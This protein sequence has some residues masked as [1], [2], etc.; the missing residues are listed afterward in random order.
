MNCQICDGKLMKRN[1]LYRVYDTKLGTFPADVCERCGEQWFDEKTAKKIEAIEKKKGL[2]G[3][4]KESKVSYSGNS[5]VI[6]IPK[7][8]AEFMNI[9]KETPVTFHPLGKNKLEIEL[10]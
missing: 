3:L 4:S 5:L 8:I 1:V 9:K 2:F 10:K 6:R 7:K